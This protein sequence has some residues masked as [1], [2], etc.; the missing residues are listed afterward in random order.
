[1]KIVWLKG[2]Y[3]GK[4]ERQEQAK[5]ANCRLVISFHFNA[6]SNSKA[7]GAE[8]Y[9]NN[10]GDAA[11]IA[12]RL[13]LVTTRLLGV[14]F[15]KVTIASG[16]RAAFI[17]FYHCPAVLIEPCF[18][19][20]PEEANLVHDDSVMRKLGESIANELFRWLPFD[21]IVGFDIGHKFKTSSISDKG[22]RCFYGDYEADHAEKL[23]KIVAASIQLKTKE[24]M[25]K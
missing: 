10:K 14:R 22:A 18:I 19:T 13:T 6:H 9:H 12:Y 3:V 7:E 21:A 20:N 11:F 8:A 23:A 17:N 5:K 15:R 2:D 16:T 24:V 25:R 4:H 1:M